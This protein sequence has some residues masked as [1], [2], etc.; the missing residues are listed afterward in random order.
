MFFISGSVV[1]ADV[2]LGLCLS[3][4]VRAARLCGMCVLEI[5]AAYPGRFFL[6]ASTWPGWLV[7]HVPLLAAA[8]PCVCICF[9]ARLAVRSFVPFSRCVSRALPSPARLV[10]SRCRFEEQERA[11]ASGGKQKEDVSD[12]VA[13]ENR[14][15]KRKLEKKEKEKAADKG[16]RYKDSFKF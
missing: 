15:R 12:I 14:K 13:E 11:A 7:S 10:C 6:C 2:R 1:E 16:K 3:L 5:G 4:V 9:Q 8:K